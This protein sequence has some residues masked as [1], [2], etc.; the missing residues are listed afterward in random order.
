MTPAPSRASFDTAFAAVVG[1][2]GG[3]DNSTHD[4]GNWTGDAVGCG[5][6]RGTKFGISAASFPSLAIADLTLDQAQA[7]YLAEY[8]TPLAAS[9]LPPPS[10]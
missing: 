9:L 3:Y 10:E 7:I 5:V 1:V 8:W 6:L 2:E 4:P